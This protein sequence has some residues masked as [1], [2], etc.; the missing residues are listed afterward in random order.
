LSALYVLFYL[1]FDADGAEKI[2]DF[3][4]KEMLINEAPKRNGSIL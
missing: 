2:Y 4:V 1:Q 3:F